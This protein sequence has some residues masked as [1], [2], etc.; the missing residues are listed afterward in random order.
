VEILNLLDDHSRP[1]LASVPRRTI[2]GH[3][4][5]HTFQDAFLR[6][7]IPASVLSDNGAVFTGK[8]NAAAASPSP[9]RPRGRARPPRGPVRPLPPLPPAHLRQG[10][11]LPADPE[12]VAGRPTT[13]P[14]ID[15]HWRIRHD[16][17]ETSG[18]VTLRHRS[19][20]HHIGLGR[21]EI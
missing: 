12:E 8:Q 18:T 5:L 20:L 9:G 21:R 11:K 10:R 2:T 15:P 6:R 3:D 13:G 1:T 14:I 19:R 16:R 7:G 4:V 17:I